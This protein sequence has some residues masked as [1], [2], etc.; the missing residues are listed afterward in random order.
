[1]EIQI[2]KIKANENIVIMKL[3]DYKNASDGHNRIYKCW[4]ESVKR[5]EEL[6]KELEEYKQIGIMQFNRP[7]AKRYLEE[8]KKEIPNLMYPD[9]ETIYEEYYNL[10]D[11]IDKAIKFI[12]THNIIGT[13][14]EYLPSGIEKCYSLELM[15]ILKGSDKE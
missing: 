14:K 3:R 13:N 5:I 6:Q 1:V 12:E 2:E 7:Y 15:D 9:S 10:K 4:R 8:K 11:R